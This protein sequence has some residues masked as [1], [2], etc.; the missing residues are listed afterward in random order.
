MG[1]CQSAAGGGVQSESRAWRAESSVDDHREV[2]DPDPSIADDPSTEP[3]IGRRVRRLGVLAVVASFVGIWGYVMYL[4][5]FEG[6][7]EPRDR[8]DDT[9]WT[10]AAEETCA[11]ARARFADVPFAVEVDSPAERAELL[12]TVTDELETMIV[13]LRGLVPP[14]EPE[15]ARAVGRWLDDW[16]EF[17]RN[18]RAYADRFRQG[19]DEP[20]RVTDRG[21]SQIDVL[22]EDFAVINNMESCAPPG[23]AG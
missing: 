13:R 3:S 1:A 5:V 22:L 23:D 19:L 12:D 10:E 14:T 16:E 4:S 6:R 21:G 15:E 2:S 8:L 7:A 9:R 17:N 11:D 18:R 20:F